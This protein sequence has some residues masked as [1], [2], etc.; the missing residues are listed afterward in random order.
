MA[1]PA[2]R[3]AGRRR[4]THGGAFSPVLEY[5][6]WAEFGRRAGPEHAETTR[7]HTFRGTAASI[8]RARQVLGYAPR[9]NSLEAL[10]EALTWLAAEGQADV[11]GQ[12]FHLAT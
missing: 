5:V 1:L 11:G 3:P 4:I 2:L 6:D 10:F 8:D 7:E 12:R 9:F